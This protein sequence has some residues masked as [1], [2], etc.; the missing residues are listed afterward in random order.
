MY[1]CNVTQRLVPVSCLSWSLSLSLTVLVRGSRYLSNVADEPTLG[2]RSR[3]GGAVDGGDQTG[4][5][6]MCSRI[7]VEDGEVSPAEE[8]VTASVD[9]SAVRYL[10][11][12]WGGK[13]CM[14]RYER[15]VET[16]ETKE[17]D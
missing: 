1:Y 17:E 3:Q 9:G 7:A 10:S 4:L 12:A 15:A 5:D 16:R 2:L 6:Y 13:G 8:W 14:V 11:V